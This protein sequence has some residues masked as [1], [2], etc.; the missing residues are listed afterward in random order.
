MCGIVGILNFD[1]SPAERTCLAAAGRKRMLSRHAWK[2]SMQRLD[3]IIERCLPSYR[4]PS[5]ALASQGR[6]RFLGSFAKHSQILLLPYV[7]TQSK[8]PIV[9]SEDAR[10][11]PAWVPDPGKYIELGVNTLADVGGSQP[12][13]DNWNSAIYASDVGTYGAI[14]LWGAGHC[15]LD[16]GVYQFG[17]GADARNCRWSRLKAPSPQWAVTNDGAGDPETGAFLDGAPAP[18]HTYDNMLYLP[19]S[20]MGNAQGSMMQAALAAVG[21]ASPRDKGWSWF[22]DISARS[23][24]MLATNEIPK[25]VP[26]REG[27]AVF[28]P[29][30]NCVWYLGNRLSQIGKFD[31]ATKTWFPIAP[32]DRQINT[33]LYLTGGYCPTLDVVVWWWSGYGKPAQKLIVWNPNTNVLI[34]D[35]PQTGSAPISVV[36][37]EWC[38]HPKVQK[39]FGVE[40]TPGAGHPKPTIRTLT[41]PASTSGRWIWENA[42]FV[43]Q[44]SV[45]APGS[46]SKNARYNALRW[47]PR[48]RSFVWPGTRTGPIN[49][50]R[51]EA[52]V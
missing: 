26:G 36:G 16:N 46:G 28:D 24:A 52:A 14:L 37:L 27:S 19:A 40:L 48:L 17:F 35:A 5:N 34:W 12:V 13:I 49:V 9:N 38:P 31:L 3:R 43:P 39:F 30:R 10:A 33:D 15:N 11:L 2:R 20:A 18:A 4:Q 32:G 23:W 47:A 51:P 29:T 42:T 6:R 22:F 25:T 7:A 41:P 1:G 21:C 8:P 44:G 45:R 50:F